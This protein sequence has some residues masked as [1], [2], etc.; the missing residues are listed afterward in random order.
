MEISGKIR[1]LRHRKNTGSAEYMPTP[2][3]EVGKRTLV[4]SI[5][6]FYRPT[7][8]EIFFDNLPAADHALGCLA[9]NCILL[10]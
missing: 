3:G 4:N 5:L 1:I 6:Q 9:V 10:L 7:K 8:G 2:T